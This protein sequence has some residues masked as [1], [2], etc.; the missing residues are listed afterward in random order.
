[1][2]EAPELYTTNPKKP[3]TMQCDASS[4]GVGAYLSQRD[5][6]GNLHHISF[7][8][9][10][11]TKAQQNWST[12]Q[13]EAYALIW[14]LKKFECYVCGAEIEWITDHNPL[15]YLQMSALQSAKLQS[16]KALVL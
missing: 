9:Y 13:H 2:C 10:K 6:K 16:E 15:I 4:Y 8:N 11:F 3:Y 12:I 1:M 5:K 7:A 14:S